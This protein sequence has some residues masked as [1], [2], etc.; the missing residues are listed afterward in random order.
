MDKIDFYEKTETFVI[1]TSETEEVTKH[2]I[3]CFNRN[4][5]VPREFKTVSEGL[6]QIYLKVV[7]GNA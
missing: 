2:L 1:R 7:N 4:S 6:E 5:I 3:E